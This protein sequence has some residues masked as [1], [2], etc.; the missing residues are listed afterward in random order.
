MPAYESLNIKEASIN[1]IQSDWVENNAM[2]DASKPKPKPTA[3]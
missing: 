2:L 3:L 1:K